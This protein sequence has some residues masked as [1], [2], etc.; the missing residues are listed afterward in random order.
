MITAAS[1]QERGE[2]CT[3]SEDCEECEDWRL[4]SV[5]T[6][7]LERPSHQVPVWGQAPLM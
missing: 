3:P 2:K 5:A 7:E 4:E 6:Q 1:E